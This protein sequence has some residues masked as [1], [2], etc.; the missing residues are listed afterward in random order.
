LHH[1]KITDNTIVH[2]SDIHLLQAVGSNSMYRINL[3][4][5]IRIN[6][7]RGCVASSCL[8]IRMFALTPHWMNFRG[9]WYWALLWKFV[10]KMPIW[11]KSGLIL[12][13]VHGPQDGYTDN[14]NIQLFYNNKANQCC[15]SMATL[16]MYI[17]LPAT[18]RTHQQQIKNIFLHSHSNHCY[19][20]VPHIYITLGAVN[21]WYIITTQ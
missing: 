7:E 4:R 11:L 6:R 10:D 19:S 3:P 14:S 13:V 20:K 17:L 9:S 1:L 21:Y 18:I 5:S 8:L 15:V 2:L 16:T 12:R